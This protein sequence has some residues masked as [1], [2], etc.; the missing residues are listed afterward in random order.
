MEVGAHPAS[1][2]TNLVYS[3]EGFFPVR[4]G[5][6]CLVLLAVAVKYFHFH[7]G[8]RSLFLTPV[9]CVVLCV[10]RREQGPRRGRGVGAS[11]FLLPQ[12]PLGTLNKTEIRSVYCQDVT[13][14]YEG[15]RPSPAKRV[16]GL[17][18][19]EVTARGELEPPVVEAG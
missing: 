4:L 17:E 14:V 1:L 2:S 7:C 10:V 13:E 15:V 12:G 5:W 19:R 11:R 18:Q 16:S 3:I 8:E 9:S 6:D